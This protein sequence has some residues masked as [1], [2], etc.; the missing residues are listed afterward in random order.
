M[1]YDIQIKVRDEKDTLV[2]II[3]G[4]DLSEGANELIAEDV[5]NILNDM[6]FK[7]RNIRY[8]LEKYEQY[9]DDLDS[10]TAYGE[11]V[12]EDRAELLRALEEVEALL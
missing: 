1:H 11:Q 2:K 5:A 4:S 3:T 7:T 6:T 10:S 9:L 8:A 12:R